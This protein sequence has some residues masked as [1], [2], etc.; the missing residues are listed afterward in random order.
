[1]R[2]L[3][4]D[5]CRLHR[6]IHLLLILNEVVVGEEDLCDQMGF[7]VAVVLDDLEGSFLGLDPPGEL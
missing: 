6:L 2:A 1:L 7:L 5:V 3:H 4:G